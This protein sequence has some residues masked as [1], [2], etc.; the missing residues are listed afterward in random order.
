MITKDDL[1]RAIEGRELFILTI[2]RNDRYI[3]AVKGEADD[4]TT[5]IKELMIDNDE[6]K[7]IVYKAVEL[8]IKFNKNN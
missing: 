7:K 8:S 1:E 3:F 4:V 6:F 2:R 5:R